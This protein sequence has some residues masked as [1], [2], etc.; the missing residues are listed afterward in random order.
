MSNW[1]VGFPDS[2]YIL[3]NVE[4]ADNNTV[5]TTTMREVDTTDY[6][7][8]S[9]E[10]GKLHNEYN[11]HIIAHDNDVNFVFQVAAPHICTG[12]LVKEQ[13]SLHLLSPQ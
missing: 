10:Q 1:D 7:L 8:N 11:K 4:S 6:D 3:S 13:L 2:F 12:M 9:T 5:A